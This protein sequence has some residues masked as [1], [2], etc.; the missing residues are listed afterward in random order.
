NTCA[1]ETVNARCFQPP[2][3]HSGGDHQSMAGNFISVS[4]LDDAIRTFRPY[5]DSFL[6]EDLH[7][8]ALRLYHRTPRQIAAAETIGEAKIIFNA[9]T[10]SRLAAGSFTL[11]NHSMQ[12]LRCAVNSGSKPSRASTDDRQVIK[13]GLRARS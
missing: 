1:L 12:S 9:R 8:K 10:H 6:R 2:P 3:L 11:H 4:H 13:V 7:A 5:A